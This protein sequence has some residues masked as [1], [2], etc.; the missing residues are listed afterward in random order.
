MKNINLTRLISR[1]FIIF[2]MLGAGNIVFSQENEGDYVPA[3]SRFQVEDEKPDAADKML[4]VF[5]FIIHV[6]I[7][8]DGI[9]LVNISFSRLI[10][11]CT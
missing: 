10:K 3:V 5:K 11:P 4:W 1:L 9:S 6:Y 2:I 7:M 8:C